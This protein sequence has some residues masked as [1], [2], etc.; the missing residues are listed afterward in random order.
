[1]DEL[2]G[3]I[4][5]LAALVLGLLGIGWAYGDFRRPVPPA[6]PSDQKS[7]R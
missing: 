3:I 2:I 4:V 5:A 6:G 1:M 7:A